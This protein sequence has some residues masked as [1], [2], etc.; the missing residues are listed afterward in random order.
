L[1]L[2]HEDEIVGRSMELRSPPAFGLSTLLVKARRQTPQQLP[3]QLHLR[4][5]RSLRLWIGPPLVLSARP[6]RRSFRA[7]CV[8]SR[9]V[10]RCIFN[11]ADVA[12][13][14]RFVPQSHPA[15]AIFR[16]CRAFA[17]QL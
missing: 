13:Y 8:L 16:L 17:P 6:R 7:S 3:L 10:E 11:L 15:P 2:F 5:R 12:F 9:Y 14:L 1:G 4:L